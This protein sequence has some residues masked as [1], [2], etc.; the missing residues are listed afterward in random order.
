MATSSVSNRPGGNAPQGAFFS[1]ALANRSAQIPG[2]AALVS[3]ANMPQG[4]GAG[5]AYTSRVKASLQNGAGPI[6]PPIAAPWSFA[7][8]ATG[9]RLLGAAIKKKIGK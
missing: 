5:A 2:A 3:F 9:K 6:I 4:T 8:F 7:S 1:N